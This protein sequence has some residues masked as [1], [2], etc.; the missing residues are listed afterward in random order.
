MAADKA[1]M[2]RQILAKL[3]DGR[4]RW[5]ASVMSRDGISVA[6]QMTRP[7]SEESFG[8]MCAAAMGA[9]EGAMLE[10]SDDRPRHATIEGAN[11]R[12]SL[13]ALDADFL[14]AVATPMTS[15]PVQSHVLE[16]DAAATRL[17]AVLKGQLVT[18]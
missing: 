9:A 11:V 8:A 18:V 6:S 3:V 14:L 4:D 13:H 10:W 2:L 16:I 7:V 1:Q 17:R 5:G 12:L 15:N